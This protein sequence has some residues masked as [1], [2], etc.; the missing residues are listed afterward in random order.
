ML[1]AIQAY[2]ERVQPSCQAIVDQDRSGEKLPV[3]GFECR[4]WLVI[5]PTSISFPSAST[6]PVSEASHT[7]GHQLAHEATQAG[8]K[9]GQAVMQTA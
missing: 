6:E 7:Q 1:C 2:F 4:S 9:R 5:G 8:S 3:A